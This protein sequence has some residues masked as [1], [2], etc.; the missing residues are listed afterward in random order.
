MVLGTQSLQTSKLLKK[1][2]ETFDD[3]RWK[4]LTK[5]K[6]GDMKSMLEMEVS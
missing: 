3:V 1:T 6:K 2:N 5:T 4:F